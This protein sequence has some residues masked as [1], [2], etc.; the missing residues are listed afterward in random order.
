[1]AAK[2]KRIAQRS[3]YRSLLWFQESKIQSGV[4]LGIVGYV[5]DRGRYLVMYHAHY[6]GDGLYHTGRTQA[7]P[8]HGLG[9]ADIHLVGVFPE[10]I[11]DGFDLSRITQ[12]GRSTVSID[13]IDVFR[14]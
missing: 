14:F 3:P 9:G 2:A 10:N 11:G 8:G 1:M 4:P 7:M 12:G 5:V 13:I 6:T